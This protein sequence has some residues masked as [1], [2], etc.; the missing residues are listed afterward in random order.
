MGSCCGGGRAPKA[1]K[2]TGYRVISYTGEEFGP[3]LTPTE[4][5]IKAME[6]GGGVIKPVREAT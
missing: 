4:A 3:F 1:G 6:V 5:N 2:V